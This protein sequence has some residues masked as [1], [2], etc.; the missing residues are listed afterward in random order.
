MIAV[1]MLYNQQEDRQ[2]QN[3][4]LYFV[5]AQN[6]RRIPCPVVAAAFGNT[7]FLGFID[8]SKGIARV[9]VLS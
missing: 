7:C 8:L 4:D 3:E 1:Q 9:D 5:P 2:D 6:I